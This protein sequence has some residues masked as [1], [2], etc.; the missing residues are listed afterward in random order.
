MTRAAPA[1]L[2]GLADRGHLGP[3]ALAD[4]AVYDDLPDRTAMFRSAHLV[5]KSGD[6]R[7]ARRRGDE[8]PPGPHARGAARR[9][10]G[11]AARVSRAILR[12][13]LRL[14]R[15]ADGRARVGRRGDGGR[16][17]RVRGSAMPEL[18]RN[19]VAVDD[20]FAE[21]FGMRAT[22]IVITADTP[23]WA[24]QAAVTMTGF[25][26]SVIACGCEAGIDAR[27]RPLRDA[28]R[29]A[30]RPRAALRRLDERCWRRSCR[31]ASASACSPAPAPPATPASTARSAIK[32]GAA[33]RY[34]GDG[35]Q[36]VEAPRRAGATGASR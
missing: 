7:R 33:I 34:F 32:L 17:N 16:R 23:E 22:A 9:S 36:I 6:A 14:A 3:G 8:S 24:R 4:V 20:T 5:F 26:T 1:R 18:I 10:S 21:A 11:D 30:G 28:R 13:A 31:C 19:G 29:A 35:W 2:L 12:G 25:A 27:T 15:R